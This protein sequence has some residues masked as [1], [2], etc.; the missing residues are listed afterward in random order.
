MND[1][2]LSVKGRRDYF[3]Q[4]KFHKGDRISLGIGKREKA[5]TTNKL[6]DIWVMKGITFKN[7]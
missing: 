6:M 1:T 5:N 4:R 2:L 7:P 3:D